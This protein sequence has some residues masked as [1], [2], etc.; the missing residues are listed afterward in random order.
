MTFRIKIILGKFSTSWSLTKIQDFG[1]PRVAR[2]AWIDFTTQIVELRP[3]EH[4]KNSPFSSF[5]PSSIRFPLLLSYLLPF[6]CSH[7]IFSFLLFLLFLSSFIFSFHFSLLDPHQPN[8]PSFFFSLIF[9]SISFSSFSPFYFSFGLHQP[10]GPKVGE[11]SPHFPP[12]PIV[13]TTIF[14]LIS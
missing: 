6:G 10:N 3:S 12:L 11:S 7:I 13:I 8:F 14:L 1:T 2:D 9:S 4:K 5:S